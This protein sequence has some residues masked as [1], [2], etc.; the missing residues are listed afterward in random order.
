MLG[1]EREV[2]LQAVQDRSR[3]RRSSVG[4]RFML[5]VDTMRDPSAG[6][7]RSNG[8]RLGEG[9]PAVKRRTVLWRASTEGRAFVQP[10]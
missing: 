6:D 2:A 5:T 7:V 4:H 1:L 9:D 10:G 3:A 8:T